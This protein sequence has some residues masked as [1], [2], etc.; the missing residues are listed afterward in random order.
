V[1][2]VTE[3]GKSEE[4]R[5]EIELKETMQSLVSRIT[6]TSRFHVELRPRVNRQPDRALS[7]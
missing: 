3:R 5:L 2:D 1:L 7:I 4:N 6:K